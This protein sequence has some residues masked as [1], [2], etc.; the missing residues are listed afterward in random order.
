[1]KNTLFHMTA[2]QKLKANFNASTKS[3]L[4]QD[5]HGWNNPFDNPI[6]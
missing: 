2:Q 4:F 5:T 1:M 3:H 6:S